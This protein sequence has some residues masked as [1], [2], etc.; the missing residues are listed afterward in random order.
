MVTSQQKYHLRVFD[1]VGEEEAH[2]FNRLF[3]SIHEIANQQKLIDGRRS[4]C[5]VKKSE[6]IIKLAMKVARYPDWAL[7]LKERRLLF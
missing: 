5:D 1:L 2:C 4:S 3:S 6:H 7:D